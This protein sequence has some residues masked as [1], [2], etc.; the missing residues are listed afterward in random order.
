MLFGRFRT[1]HECEFCTGNWPGIN[2]TGNPRA[3]DGS[4]PRQKPNKKSYRQPPLSGW[5]AARRGRGPATA[6]TKATVNPRSGQG[7]RQP[8]LSGWLPATA[9]EKKAT[10]NP[11]SRQGYRQPS[12]SGWLPE[13]LQKHPTVNTN[14][15]TL[16]ILCQ[17]AKKSYRQR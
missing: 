8:P 14:I 11:R 10:V 17:S 16:P 5:L 7:Y 12:L 1:W 4:R 3:A 6:K 9:E 13:Q 15:L 2:C